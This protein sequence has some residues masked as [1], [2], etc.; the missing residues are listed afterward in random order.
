MRLLITGGAG[1]IGS[2]LI[3][4]ILQN[5][6]YTVLNVDKLTY[7][8]SPASLT[9]LAKRPNY[10]FLRA[11]IAARQP[12]Q[13]A[14]HN[15]RPDAV[16]HLAAESHVDR[17]IDHPA[18]FMHSNVQGTYQLLES[19]R[20]Y[21]QQLEPTSQA[22]F[23][24]LHVSTDEVYG[25]RS[26]AGSPATEHSSYNP[27]SPY[28]ASKAASDHLV[29]AWQRTYGIPVLLSHC[30]NNYG[31]YQFPEKLIPLMILNAQIGR[32]LPIYGDGQQRRDWL[33]VDDHV[34]A[35]L[36]IL[37]NGQPGQSYNISSQHQHSNLNVVE[38]LCELLEELAPRHPSGISRYQDLITQVED[39]PGHDRCYALNSNYLRHNL[40][41]QPQE[42]FTS[43]LRKTLQWY[44]D[45]ASWCQHIQNGNA[46]RARLGKPKALLP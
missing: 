36:L 46:H 24:F 37:E 16:I 5:T 9:Q 40:G 15:F 18:A 34:R 3:R 12:I 38:I 13:Q 45:N 33:Y 14:L 23:R 28:A 26:E 21:W 30:T 32:P 17:S 2:A 31:P 41:W 6:G 42:S 22:A 35:L 27:S 4:Y 44:L 1:F 25:D 43:G 19:V 29:R 8:A 11:D 20:H 10:S 39:R 7:A